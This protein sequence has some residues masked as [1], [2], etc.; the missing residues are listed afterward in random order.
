MFKDLLTPETFEFFASFVLA[1]FIIISVRTRFAIGERASLSERLVEAVVLSLI[2]QVIF[3]LIVSLAT[4]LG[5][6]GLGE[7]L[8]DRTLFFIEI[9]ALPLMLGVF[10]GYNLTNGWSL[11]LF[12]RLGMPI[13]HPLDH[14]YDYA[15]Q[16]QREPCF[17]IVTY[18][19]G[20]KIYGFYGTES[21]AASDAT[22]GDLFLQRL[23]TV[24]EQANGDMQWIEDKVG[25]SVLIT[26]TSIRSIEFLDNPGADDA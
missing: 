11:A 15:F 26:L 22:R 18:E 23:Y 25:R 14:A 6:D 13:S 1:G 2:N 16:R 12:R 7:Y 24:E 4:W 21:F 20:T 8:P 9:L 3:L 19:D 17:V 10:F 5:L